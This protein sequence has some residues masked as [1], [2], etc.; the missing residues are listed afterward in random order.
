MRLKAI[1]L[2]LTHKNKNELA[3]LAGYLKN[4]SFPLK[5]VANFISSHLLLLF[6]GRKVEFPLGNYQGIILIG[7]FVG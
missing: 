6:L 4:N 1:S 2:L 5:V 7:G 3:D